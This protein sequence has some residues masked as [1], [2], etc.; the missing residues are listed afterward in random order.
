MRNVNYAKRPLC[1]TSL[2]VFERIMPN[3]HYAKCPLCQTSLMSWTN[4]AKRPLCQTSI[5]KTR[6]AKCPLCQMGYTP[7]CRERYDDHFGEHFVRHVEHF[8]G[9]QL[10]RLVEAKLGGE[11]VGGLTKFRRGGQRDK[12]LNVK[13]LEWDEIND[14]L[15]AER[16]VDETEKPYRS[17]PSLLHSAKQSA[18]DHSE[19]TNGTEEDFRTQH[20][21]NTMDR[22]DKKGLHGN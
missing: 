8:V 4:Y 16:K 22:M 13:Q 18:S 10:D 15:Q 17:M 2:M 12:Q 21:F 3:V 20:D 9:P 7:W 6:Y 5:L 19:I 11:F 14:L 1:Q